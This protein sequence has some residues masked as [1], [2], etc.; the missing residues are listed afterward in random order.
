MMPVVLIKDRTP[1]TAGPE[2]GKGDDPISRSPHQDM[3]VG[4]GQRLRPLH[5]RYTRTD[6]RFR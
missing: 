4:F 5:N 6:T 2:E 1:G 3:A